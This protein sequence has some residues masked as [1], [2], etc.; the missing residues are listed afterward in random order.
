MPE[1]SPIHNI[2]PGGKMSFKVIVVFITVLIIAS[3]AEARDMSKTILHDVP[4]EVA[5]EQF[6]ELPPREIPELIKQELSKRRFD[7]DTL[8]VL[9]VLVEW[10]NRPGTYP[11]SVFQD[12][13]FSR[14]TYPGGS[15][16]DYFH[17]VSYGQVAVVGNV[18]NWFNAGFYHPDYYFEDLIPILDP[19]VNFSN[20]DGD[21]D[22]MVDMLV[23]IRSGTGEE[24][25]GDPNDIWSHALTYY[26]GWE[27]GPYDGVMIPGWN[28][29]PEMRPLRD[30][31]NPTLFLPEDTLNHIRVFA[32]E[33]SHGLGLPDLYDY[34][35]KLD[36]STYDTPNDD[37][38]HPFMDWC[39]MGYAG[40]G[41]FSIKSDT[42]SHLSG[43]C[44]K[45]MGWLDPVILDQ[46]EY[47]GLEIYNIETYSENSLYILPIDLE[48]GEYFLLE[49]RNPHSSGLFDKVD[50][51]FS[52]FFWPHLTFGCDTLDQGLLISHVDDSL[53]V[54]PFRINYGYPSYP[55]YTV[56]VV[57]AGYN[58]GQDAYSNPEGFVTDSAN[59]WYPYETRL[60]ALFSPDVP[61]Q[62]ILSPSTVPSSD[63]YNGPTGITVEVTAM[64]NDKLTVNIFVDADADGFSNDFDNC[65]EIY[66]PDQADWDGN[67]IGDL[68]DIFCG[69]LNGDQ[70]I[71]ILDII[72]L[73]DYKFKGGPAPD[74]LGAADVNGDLTVNILDIVYLIDYKFKG[75][76]VP[77]CP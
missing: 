28:T 66:N 74:P 56:A 22:G 5:K 41:L 64:D 39:L 9:A 70:T 20:Y 16:A 8:K 40:Y 61:G 63:G 76:P 53:G 42:P 68:C 38:D 11:Q 27:E 23:F 30:P 24:D 62:N 14:N 59:W 36:I 34:D 57:D 26:P 2:S 33:M 6:G 58:P 45:Q 12:M 29:S 46:S 32:H 37:N 67:G 35:A 25:S 71:N 4:D 48:A 49:Y 52:V 51:D 77:E 55:H 69:D 47:T 18:I 54:D 43:W 31:A 65:P 15:I 10:N 75:G 7:G 60:G 73:I 13:M 72:L 44:K 50:S 19:Y 1:K 17:E 21:G 3:V